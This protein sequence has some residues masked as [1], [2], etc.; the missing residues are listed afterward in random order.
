M[1]ATDETEHVK[2]VHFDM[3]LTIKIDGMKKKG[4]I[5]LPKIKDF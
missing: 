3:P 5:L 2:A 1:T 4:V